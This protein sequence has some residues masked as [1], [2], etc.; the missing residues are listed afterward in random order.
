MEPVTSSVETRETIDS[1]MDIFK[2]NVQDHSIVSE[3]YLEFRNKSA[4]QR[5]QTIDIFVEKTNQYYIDF[6]RSYFKVTAK[7]TR[8]KGGALIP[9]PAPAPAAPGQSPETLTDPQ[10]QDK[11]SYINYPAICIFSSLQMQIG[12][13][14]FARNC[15]SLL[16]Y[17]V[18]IDNLTQRST[19][20]LNSGN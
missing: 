7:I 1:R 8:E 17:K 19:E 10:P 16:P 20:Y 13:T 18:M 5:N 6:S 2:G 11:C 3:R 4:V 9:P 15:S 12:N 14:D